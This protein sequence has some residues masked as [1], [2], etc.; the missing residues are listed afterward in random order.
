MTSDH[1]EARS[2]RSVSSWPSALRPL[3]LRA[4]RTEQIHDADTE[5]IGQLGEGL[6]G[7]VLA[8]SLDAAE[9][10]NGHIKPF[11]QAF[12]RR[13]KLATKLGYTSADVDFDPRGIFASHEGEVRGLTCAAPST[14]RLKLV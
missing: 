12:L 13:R 7:Q 9:P 8:A 5:R 10:L 1:A 3:G 2:R 11:S 14:Y 6:D 4:G